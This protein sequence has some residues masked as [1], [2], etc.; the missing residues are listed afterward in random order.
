MAVVKRYCVEDAPVNYNYRELLASDVVR[1]TSYKY[2]Y[3]KAKF[4]AVIDKLLNYKRIGKDAKCVYEE[5]AYLQAVVDLFEIM[6][7][8]SGCT[9]EDTFEEFKEEYKL[10]CIRDNLTC[11]YGLGDMVEELLEVLGLVTPNIGIGYMTIQAPDADPDCSPF[12][13]TDPNA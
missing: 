2:L 3:S 12:Q 10:D 4:K 1:N 5:I 6:K 8:E 9:T 11:R 7:Q 13:P